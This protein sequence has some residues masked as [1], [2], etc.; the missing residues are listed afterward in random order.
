MAGLMTADVWCFSCF[1]TIE[2]P[3]SCKAK[4]EL[5]WCLT[6]LRPLGGPG[7]QRNAGRWGGLSTAPA[8]FGLRDSPPFPRRGTEDR[9]A[10]KDVHPIRSFAPHGGVSVAGR[11]GRPARADFWP[12][13]RL[14]TTWLETKFW[15]QVWRYSPRLEM[16]ETQQNAVQKLSFQK[17]TLNQKVHPV[18]HPR[19]NLW[20]VNFRFWLDE[21]YRNV[22]PN[23]VQWHFH[24]NTLEHT[25]SL[26]N[27]IPTEFLRQI[28]A[29][30]N[31]STSELQKTVRCWRVLYIFTCNCASRHSGVQFFDMVTSKSA[32][33]PS[34]F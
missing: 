4:R 13:R 6:N 31:F 17:K 9:A 22:R 24:L 5:L 2:I 32:P 16:P 12:H 18:S 7:G 19:S 28:S 33:T 8:V 10:A 15:I 23:F 3:K 11:R 29:L 21:M 20:M 1:K 30:T 34:V 14:P 25:S 27:Q 26:A